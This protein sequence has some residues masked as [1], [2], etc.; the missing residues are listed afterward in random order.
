MWAKR[1]GWAESIAACERVALSHGAVRIDVQGLDAHPAVLLIHGLSYPLEVWGPLT[2]RLVAG[3]WRV[4]RYDL[5]GRGYST[6]DET[7]LSTEVLV[8][9]ACEVL[10][11]VGETRPV[12]VVSM[13]NADLIACGLAASVPERVSGLSF[14]AP[15]GLDVRTM[16]SWTRWAGQ[17][18]FR[19]WIASWLPARLIRRMEDHAS[20]LPHDAEPI[21]HEAYAVAMHTVRHNPDFGPAALSHLSHL[22][23]D[24]SFMALLRELANAETPVLGVHYKEESDATP[25]GVAMFNTQLPLLRVKEMERGTHMGVLEHPADL[26]QALQDAWGDSSTDP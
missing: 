11:H 17:S 8:Q 21:S 25:E 20:H 10:D 15:S 24:P 3:G 7:P 12:Q 5:Y 14:V 4:I 22:P 16:N 6:W 26:A 2:A 18:W 23:D 19:G 13:S 1:L 9:Q